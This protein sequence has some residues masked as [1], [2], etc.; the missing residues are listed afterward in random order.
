MTLNDPLASVLSGILNH[1]KVSKKV[2]V[3][4]SNSK[5]IR[6]VLDILRDN[7][8]IGAYE[9]TENGR[10]GLLSINLLGK[11]NKVGVIKPRYQV[12]FSEINNV[13]NQHLPARGFGLLFISTNQGLMTNE[14]AKE[15]GIGGRLIGYCY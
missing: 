5:L 13:E 1:E 12:K 14:E 4:Q 7:G 15:K 9:V 8:Y 10:G 2:F 11:I 6:N 3:T